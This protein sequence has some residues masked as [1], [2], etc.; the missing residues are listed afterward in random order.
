M[1]QPLLKKLVPVIAAII[2]ALF[3]TCFL[4]LPV[5]VYE[6]PVTDSLVPYGEILLTNPLVQCLPDLRDLKGYNPIDLELLLATYNRSNNGSYKLETFAL[7]GSTRSELNTQMFNANDVQ[8]N[9]YRSFTVTIPENSKELCFSLS[10]AG[11]STG[12]AL[13]IWLNS[14]NEPILRIRA[15]TSLR[16]LLNRMASQNVFGIGKEALFGLSFGYLFVQFWLI[17]YLIWNGQ[18][19]I[20]KFA[21]RK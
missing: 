1:K 8:D 20:S 14:N 6:N 9:K 13:T 15:W 10:A 16:N 21:H 3:L 17:I 4:P 19:K 18:E 5:T 12:N 7:Q 2:L 11:A